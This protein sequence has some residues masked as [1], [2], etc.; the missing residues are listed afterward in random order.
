MSLLFLLLLLLSFF[1]DNNDD[2]DNGDD[3]DD[4][5][6]KPDSRSF[7]RCDESSFDDGRFLSAS[8]SA[9]SSS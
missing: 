6:T 1:D 8:S 4:G 9:A 2:D 7:W 3:D 5:M